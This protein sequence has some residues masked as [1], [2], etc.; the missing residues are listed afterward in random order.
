MSRVIYLT[1]SQPVILG[2]ALIIGC[3]GAI[4]RADYPFFLLFSYNLPFSHP[5]LGKLKDS[6]HISLADC[7]QQMYSQNCG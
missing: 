5:F 2:L 1:Y 6:S 4:V 7:H 3:F